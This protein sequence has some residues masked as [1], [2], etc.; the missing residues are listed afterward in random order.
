MH[1]Q[2]GARAQE[3]PMK[4]PISHFW[5][6]LCKQEVEAKEFLILASLNAYLNRTQ[7]FLGKVGRL[8]CSKQFGK[9]TSS[10]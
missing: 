1:R 9:F 10:W 2:G 7:S 4:T 8:I 5:L 3:K 6:T